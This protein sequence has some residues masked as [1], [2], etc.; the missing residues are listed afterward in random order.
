M[1]RGTWHTRLLVVVVAALPVTPS[2]LHE[3][4]SLAVAPDACVIVSVDGGLPA[5]DIRAYPVVLP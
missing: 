2:G 1:A 3:D 5:S 4:L